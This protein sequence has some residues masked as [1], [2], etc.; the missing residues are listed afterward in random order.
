MNEANE[1]KG[2]L[3]ST[4]SLSQSFDFK[5]KE[6]FLGTRHGFGIYLVGYCDQYLLDRIF[7][8]LFRLTEEELGTAPTA[9]EF[10]EKLLPYPSTEWQRDPDRVSD[11]ILRGSL[12]LIL[13]GYE[14]AI[15]LDTRSFALRGPEEPEKDRSLRGPHL[16]FNE[17]LVSNLVQIRRYLRCKELRTKRF[18]LGTK[19]R[20]EVALL[21]LEGK[22]NP[23]TVKNLSHRLENASLPALSMTQE[24]LSQFL[25]P[26]KG[27]SLMNPFPKVR[28]TERPDVIAATLMEG[29]VAV[30][31]DNSPSVM[32]IPECIFDFF[33]EVDDYYFPPVTASYLRLVR[34]FVFLCSV[35]LIPI[36][37]IL[38][39]RGVALPEEFRF[40]L[41]EGEFAVPLYLQFLTIELAIDGLRMASLNTPNTLSNSFSV[42]GGLL[43][44]EYA[45]KSGWFVPQTILYSAFTGIANFIPTNYEL[46]YS[47]KFIRISL[48]LLTQFSGIGGL[49][50]GTALWLLILFSTRSAAGKGYLYPFLPWDG[51]AI[52][53]ILFRTTK[54]RE[55]DLNFKDSVG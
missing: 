13:D 1:W 17:S 12:C 14:D 30:L 46:G 9:R 8:R 27:L 49:G 24:T 3:E 38:V 4:L 45:V 40:L 19:I 36:W 55:R 7:T 6:F 16:G 33:E 18:L 48:I 52:G 39:Q 43:L 34:S 31:C 15:L 53:K 2:K 54:G 47:F 41:T 35:F 29:K 11:E 44:G 37:L 22:C 42:I 20:N 23:V 32:L 51:K 26:A 5:I 21:Y 28:Y 25:F 50:I 10:S